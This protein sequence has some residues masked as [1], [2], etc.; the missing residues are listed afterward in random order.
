[1]KLS[2]QIVNFAVILIVFVVFASTPVFGAN[3]LAYNP[4]IENS[5]QQNCSVIKKDLEDLRKRDISSRVSRVYVYNFI[6][7][8]TEAF[9]TR[10]SNNDLSNDDVVA[11]NK[12]LDKQLNNFKTEFSSYD[13]SL[14][15]LLSTECS[16]TKEFYENLQT[17][18]KDRSAVAKDAALL[19]SISKDLAKEIKQISLDKT[20]E[21]TAGVSH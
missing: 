14:T 18:R 7:Q 17:V 2:S 8:R 12:Q 13:Q 15:T 21:G 20:D 10:L 6:L 16:D 9:A 11:L 19:Q 3:Y 5:I 1:M 4:K